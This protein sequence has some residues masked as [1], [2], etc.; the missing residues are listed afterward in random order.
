MITKTIELR[1]RMTFIPAIAILVSGD[2]GYLA[3]RAGYE[4]PCVLFGRLDGNGPLRCDAFEWN[5]RTYHVAHLYIEEHF[6]ELPDGAVVDVAF[7]LGETTE[8]KTSEGGGE[9]ESAVPE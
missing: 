8:P 1:D 2:D 5:D 6:S 9:N 7:I 4:R 3:R